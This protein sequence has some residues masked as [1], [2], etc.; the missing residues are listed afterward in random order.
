MRLT[1]QHV[2]KLMRTDP[3]IFDGRTLWLELRGWQAGHVEDYA[4]QLARILCIWARLQS[5]AI[6]ETSVS[7]ST[8]W[9]CA[10]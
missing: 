1:T 9:W 6:G 10:A 3:D 2:E 5:Q 4:A 7:L 8:S